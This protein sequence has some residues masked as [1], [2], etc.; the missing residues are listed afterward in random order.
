MAVIIINDG[1]NLLY[2]YN[3]II[4]NI[5]NWIIIYLW[6]NCHAYNKFV[7]KMLIVQTLH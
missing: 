5:I 3:N 7:L 1:N 4:V 6:H 2:D